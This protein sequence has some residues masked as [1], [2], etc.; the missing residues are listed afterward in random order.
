MSFA[1]SKRENLAYISTDNDSELALNN[2][3][4]TQNTD[5]DNDTHVKS[6]KTKGQHTSG[7]TN[8]G[9]KEEQTI[10]IRTQKHLSNFHKSIQYN[11]YKSKIC[12][13]AWPFN[14]KVQSGGTAFVVM[15]IVY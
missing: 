9:S 2:A 12:F 8:A 7:L 14:G 1:L 5:T 13:E 11:M 10:D 4:S 6:I 15:M 3:M